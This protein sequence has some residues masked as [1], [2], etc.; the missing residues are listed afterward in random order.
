MPSISHQLAEEARKTEHRQPGFAASLF[1]G[2]FHAAS[3]L[4]YP[5]QERSDRLAGDQFCE[6]LGD[7]LRDHVDADAIDRSREI[8]ASVMQGLAAL[9]WFGIKIPQAYGGLGLSQVNYDRAM[10]LVA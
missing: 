7:F 4:P 1:M 10:A 9:G 2:R 8:P 3:I 5:A 6:R